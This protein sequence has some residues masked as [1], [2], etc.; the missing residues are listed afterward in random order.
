MRE[1]ETLICEEVAL[2]AWFLWNERRSWKPR[3]V[4]FSRAG[5]MVS[6]VDVRPRYESAG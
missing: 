6:E 2:L 4:E 1:I 5:K 3:I